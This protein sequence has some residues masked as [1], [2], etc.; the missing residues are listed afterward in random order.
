VWDSKAAT[1]HNTVATSNDNG[2]ASG[3]KATTQH[4]TV[5]ASND[6]GAASGSEDPVEDGKATLAKNAKDVGGHHDGIRASSFDWGE[7]CGREE[8]IERGQGDG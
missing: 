6:N 8:G 4:N 1:Q 2:A 3:S 5:A 7:E